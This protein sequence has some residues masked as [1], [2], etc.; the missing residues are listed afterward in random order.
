M[1]GNA[2]DTTMSIRTIVK[3]SIVENLKTTAIQMVEWQGQK[4]GANIEWQG[5][6]IWILFRLV[7]IE[8]ACF[9]N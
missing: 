7:L 4:S 1:T 3:F 8:K 6:K 5:R 2:L 9:L